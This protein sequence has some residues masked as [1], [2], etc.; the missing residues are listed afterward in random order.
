MMRAAWV[1]QTQTER[2][3][4]QD[5]ANRRNEIQDMMWVRGKD[6]DVPEAL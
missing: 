6:S 1:S 4:M 3:R 2:K 5:A